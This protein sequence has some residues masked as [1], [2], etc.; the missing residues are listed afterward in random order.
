MATK[1]FDAKD[2]DIAKLFA[3]R[4]SRYVNER[5]SKKRQFDTGLIK[6]VHLELVKAVNHSRISFTVARV[7]ND[8]M[9][10]WFSNNPDATDVSAE[11]LRRIINAALLPMR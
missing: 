8:S 6:R 2:S 3:Q 5:S 10:D 1:T 7:V 9:I 11:E 4:L